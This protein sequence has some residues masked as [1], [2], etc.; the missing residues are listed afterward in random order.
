MYKTRNDFRSFIGHTD[1]VA[2]YGKAWYVDYYAYDPACSKM[3]RKRHSVSMKLKP[4]ERNRRMSA[5]LRNINEFLQAGGNPWY[6]ADAA[7]ELSPFEKCLKSY[8]NEIGKKHKENTR[9]DYTS[10]LNI[11]EDYI[12]N[13]HGLSCA[14]DFNTCFCI[15]FLD[16]LSYD[17]GRSNKTR[18]NYRRWLGT[19]ANHMIARGFISKNPIDDIPV[20]PEEEKRRMPLSEDMLRK[21]STYLAEHDKHFL[22]ACLM[23]YYTLIRPGELLNLKIGDISISDSTI[24]VPAWTSKNGKDGVVGLNDSVLKLMI[25]LEIF[26]YP[27]SY[28]LFGVEMLPSKEHGNDDQLNRKWSE[29]RKIFG[30][31]DCFQF[32]SLKD[33]G[34]RDLA[35]AKGIIVARDQARHADVSTTNKYVSQHVVHECTKHFKGVL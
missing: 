32:Y 27:S 31:S 35:N 24:F 16:Y 14:K 8:R 3:R 15:G 7:N 2:H 1:P 28:Y 34:I 9:R 20:F 18:N 22:L 19:F 11:L 4:Q 23:E 30:W 12:S 6:N 17:K 5:L 26:K 29:I 13:G 10:R 25:E 21:L 33:S